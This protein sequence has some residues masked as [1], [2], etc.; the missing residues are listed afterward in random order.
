MIKTGGIED[1]VL[2]TWRAVQQFLVRCPRTSMD[3]LGFSSSCPGQR[4]FHLLPLD[5]TPVKWSRTLSMGFMIVPSIYVL[6]E[7]ECYRVLPFMLPKQS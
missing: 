6:L 5:S 3:R 2:G 7:T 4:A 1:A